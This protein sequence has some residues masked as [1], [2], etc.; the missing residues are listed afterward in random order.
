MA[1]VPAEV[2]ERALS[3]GMQLDTEQAFAL[4]EALARPAPIADRRYVEIAGVKLTR[5]ELEVAVMVAKG[6]SN[7]Q[8]AARLVLTERTVEGHVEN[9]LSKLHFHSRAAV[10]AWVVAQNELAVERP[11]QPP[12]KVRPP[13]ARKQVAIGLP[14]ELGPDPHRLPP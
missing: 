3:E 2:V 5:R 14:P 11:P 10:A 6:M 7:R 1:T 8:I 12:P 4:A 9:L 13:P